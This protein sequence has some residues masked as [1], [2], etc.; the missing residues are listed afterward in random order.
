MPDTRQPYQPPSQPTQPWRDEADQILAAADQ[1]RILEEAKRAEM[2][3]RVAKARWAIASLHHQLQNGNRM[4]FDK[5]SFQKEIFQCDLQHVR[6]VGSTGW[7]KTEYS[8]CNMLAMAFCG[9]RVIHVIEKYTKRNNFVGGELNPRL[10][11]VAWYAEMIE[12]AKSVQQQAVNSTS[13]KHFGSGYVN[14]IG[15]QSEGDFTGY[16]ADCVQVDD[17]QDCNQENLRMAFDRMNGSPYA[18]T[19]FI[20]NPRQVGTEENQNIDWEYK[21]SDQR[22][23]HVPCPYCREFQIL[24]WW[25][26]FVEEKKNKFGA[27]TSV[28]IRDK[29][30]RQ[31]GI[32]EYRPLCTNCQMPMD[33]L[34]RQGKWVK[35]APSNKLVA[36]FRKSNLVVPTTKMWELFDHYRKGLHDPGAMAKFVNNQLGMPYSASGSGIDDAM[37]QS[38]STGQ[39]C[40]MPAYRLIPAES[41]QW[42]S[43]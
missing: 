20:G 39:A 25:S 36:G 2:M 33:R 17:H 10:G 26:H 14:F 4:N 11:K 31:R 3:A 41:M 22:E 37:L 13:F 27:I 9:L 15:S 24:D 1:E 30:R 8:I 28:E 43:L 6:L 7:G 42:R 18:F 38:A 23:W 12:Y 5:W 16:R 29:E 21:Q 34:S 32:L 19:C 40:K 35:L